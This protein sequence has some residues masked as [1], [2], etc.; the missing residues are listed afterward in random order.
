ML[1]RKSASCSC[2]NEH[3]QQC[4]NV[5]AIH[6]H[7]TSI[8]LFRPIETEN[9]EEMIDCSWIHSV[10]GLFAVRLCQIYTLKVSIWVIIMMYCAFTHAII[11]SLAREKRGL[12]AI[13]SV[14][15]PQ[16]VS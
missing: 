16:S 12:S 2:L 9:G 1:S 6:C 5:G 15:R 4:S 7:L 14:G 11:S 3:G 10:R 8:L 13:T